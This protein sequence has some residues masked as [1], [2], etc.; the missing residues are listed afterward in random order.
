MMLNGM[1]VVLSPHLTR[2]VEDWSGVRSPA[3]ARRRRRQGH[4]Q[5]IAYVTRDMAHA[6]VMNGTLFV[7]PDTF[8]RLMKEFGR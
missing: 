7:G 1:K 8:D 6:F 4:K 5:R 3:R 2:M